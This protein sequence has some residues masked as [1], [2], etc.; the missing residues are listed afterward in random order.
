MATLLGL[1]LL[2]LNLTSQVVPAAAPPTPNVRF[3]VLSSLE[4]EGRPQEGGD[5]GSAVDLAADGRS[6]VFLRVGINRLDFSS[7]KTVPLVSDQELRAGGLGQLSPEELHVTAAANRFIYV[8]EAGSLCH[9]RVYLL[10]VSPFSSKLL[11]EATCGQ[12]RL[13]PAKTHL[14]IIS[15]RHNEREGRGQDRLLLFLVASGAMLFD[16]QITPDYVDSYW[17]DDQTFELRY[18]DRFDPQ[19]QRY[20]YKAVPLRGAGDGQWQLGPSRPSPKPHVKD[21]ACDYAARIKVKAEGT[22]SGVAQ[23]DASGIFPSLQPEYRAGPPRAFR[24]G[25]VVAVVRRIVE[26][27]PPPGVYPRTRDQIAVLKLNQAK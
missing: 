11:A 23:L 10:T 13:S 18:Q 2:G 7:G 9:S 19:E 16:G 15:G 26:K 3:D 12:A 25:E 5:L 27:N 20:Y 8:E 17:E 24:A 22:S 21:I 6:L 14:A 1:L 4:I